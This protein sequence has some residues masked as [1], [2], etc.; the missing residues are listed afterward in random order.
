MYQLIVKRLVHQS[1]QSLSQGDYEKVLKQFAPTIHFIFAGEHILGGERH[2]VQAMRQ[3]FQRFF[4]LLPGL[5]FQVHT[6][7]V[8]GWPWNTIV[9]THFS[10][11]TSLQDGRPYHNTGVQLLRLRWGKAVEDFIYE[12]TQKLASLLQQLD[13]QG[14]S[15]ASTS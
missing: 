10:V 8:N 13:Q 14:V 4:Q 9:A 15:E 12:D 2:G 5:Q 7:L 11:Q 1:F 6:V 3:W